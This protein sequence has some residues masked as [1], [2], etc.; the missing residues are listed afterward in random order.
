[1]KD[2]AKLQGVHNY[3]ILSNEIYAQRYLYVPVR[4]PKRYKYVIS[5]YNFKEL[6][7]SSLDL[8]RIVCDLPYLDKQRA[9][10]IVFSAQDIYLDRIRK[11]AI[12]KGIFE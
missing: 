8:V 12:E 1:M 2:K 7:K 5:R 6:R 4:F 11:N 9:L 10:N 3:D